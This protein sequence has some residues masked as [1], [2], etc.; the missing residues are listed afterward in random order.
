[1]SDRIGNELQVAVFPNPTRDQFTLSIDA[2]SKVDRM[3]IMDLQ[4]RLLDQLAP[5]DR[6]I[7]TSHLSSGQYLLQIWTDQG[8][9]VK[10]F[11]IE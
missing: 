10:P 5:T 6:L 8:V 2:R 9:A 4:G 1:M 7:S 11:V 3:V